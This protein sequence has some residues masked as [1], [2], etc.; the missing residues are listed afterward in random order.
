MHR[1]I[2]CF[3]MEY[4]RYINRYRAI[5][6]NVD[7]L[8]PV[9]RR[10]LLV[11]YE[12][13]RDK[14]VKAARINGTTMAEYHPHAEPH[15]AL[16]KLIENGYVYGEG[17]WGT[18]GLT[19]DGPAAAR[20]CITA[21]TRVSTTKGQIKIIDLKPNNSEE[22][23]DIEIFNYCGEKKKASKFFDSGIDNILEIETESGYSL[24]GNYN[25]PIIILNNQMK[26]EWKLLKNIQKDDIAVLK[27]NPEFEIENDPI[28]ETIA[29]FLGC[30]I[31]EGCLTPK[32]PNKIIFNNTDQD[33]FNE[34]ENCIKKLYPN[35]NYYKRISTLPSNKLLYII[36]F[37][38]K[39]IID[40]ISII[41]KWF[42][43]SY[44][45][46]R[47]IPECI[48]KTSRKNQAIFLKYLFTGDGSFSSNKDKMSVGLQYTSYS[49]K[50]LK[51]IQLILL[52]NFGILSSISNNNR[53]HKLYISGIENCKKFYN[54]IGFY[55]EKNNKLE[56]FIN[57]T[58]NIRTK[59]RINQ[60]PGFKEYLKN[61]Y[62]RKI[63]YRNYKFITKYFLDHRSGINENK[64]RLFLFIDDEDKKLIDI[65]LNTDYIFLKITNIK[66]LP[67]ENVYCIRVES[68][69]HSFLA[70]GFINHNTEAKL[71]KW[72]SELAFKYID[73]KYIPWI[74]I[75]YNDEP[76]ALPCP[77]PLGLVGYDMI[78]GI[79]FYS[80][81]IPRF[82]L[83]DLSKRMTWILE[84][85]NNRL[86]K[87]NIEEDINESKY[88][89]LI[90]PNF[91][92]CVLKEKNSGEFYKVLIEGGGDF[93]CI[94]LGTYQDNSIFI[95]G[96][97]P[98][99]AFTS[100]VNACS[101]SKDTGKQEIEASI[102]DLSCGKD[103]SLSE[104]EKR[105]K[106]LIELEF[107]KN[108]NNIK[109]TFKEIWNKYLISNIKFTNYF[110]D[111][112]G[113]LKIYGIDD[114]LI[115]N[116]SY[117][118]TAI[119][120]KRWLDCVDAIDNKF[121]NLVTEVIKDIF[122]R[123]NCKLVDDVINIYNQEHPNLINV[124]L[125][126]FNQ[127]T[128]S[129]NI[130]NKSIT[131]EDINEVCDSKSIRKL[132]QTKVDIQNLENKI[133][134]CKTEISNTD[135]Y[136]YQFIKGLS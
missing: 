107:K 28:N 111:D 3:Y 67:D 96:R 36:E 40:K 2:P 80:T 115:R 74:N 27:I 31:S 25:H 5:P 20:Y 17:G 123:H 56:K 81:I 63:G 6:Y 133:T 127:D 131:N 135:N 43:R 72:V 108:K 79:S 75:E 82:T 68:D 84:N 62:K 110:S 59:G 23:I 16:D 58:T 41:D 90:K 132:I 44:S 128:N 136:C 86:D 101:K 98:G 83:K 92:D 97:V 42:T 89:P 57:E 121:K 46:D 100:L 126:Y 73:K 125:D 37:C 8:K 33:Y 78:T 130:Y 54:F 66:Q 47:E 76:I 70:N 22:D 49:D 26:L 94:P 103:K 102:I 48:W 35:I 106:I 129:W 71:E 64:K 104:Y 114:I 18:K 38:N 39:S 120:R 119:L 13:A 7:A 51:D 93:E 77:V 10:L 11:C 134:E 88:G 124:P 65:L 19:N 60:I 52:T 21:D 122:L 32:N 53:D 112:N 14:L 9:E 85:F 55:G 24:K 105:Y 34:Y 109:D 99:T 87:I 1:I 12:I 30:L 61:K 69:C 113:R 118:R 45:K 29:K 95:K 116:Y 91:R 50:L 15:N 117:W 4:G